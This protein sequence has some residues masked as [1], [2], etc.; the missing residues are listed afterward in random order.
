LGGN[1][2]KKKKTKKITKKKVCGLL[3]KWLLEKSNFEGF[4]SKDLKEY[5][6]GKDVATS[7]NKETLENLD[8][9]IPT[10]AEYTNRTYSK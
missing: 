3:Q 8:Q 5:I 10:S 7:V 6:E 2:K 4:L 1:F 9:F